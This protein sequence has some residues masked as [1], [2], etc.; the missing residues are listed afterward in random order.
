MV[1]DVLKMVAYFNV[2]GL[3]IYGKKYHGYDAGK[4]NLEG[5][6]RRKLRWSK[7]RMDTTL[8]YLVTND[9]VKKEK[10]DVGSRLYSIGFC[11]KALLKL[12]IT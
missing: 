11:Y 5:Y 10:A 3:D 4:D 1:N 6:F 7:K 12:S 9:I 2:Y 8:K